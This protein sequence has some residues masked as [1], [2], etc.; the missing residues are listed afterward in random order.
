METKDVMELR[1][2]Q[3][4]EHLKSFY[5]LLEKKEANKRL[6]HD[7]CEQFNEYCDTLILNPSHPLSTF[8]KSHHIGSG[9]GYVKVVKDFLFNT[10]TRTPADKICKILA[11]LVFDEEQTEEIKLNALKALLGSNWSPKPEDNRYLFKFLTYMLKKELGEEYDIIL[12]RSLKSIIECPDTEI[13]TPASELL[14]AYANKLYFTSPAESE[15]TSG[16]QQGL[17]LRPV[18][19]SPELRL[20]IIQTLSVVTPPTGALFDFFSKLIQFSDTILIDYNNGVKQSTATSSDRRHILKEAEAITTLVAVFGACATR[21]PGCISKLHVE[22]ISTCSSLLKM[23]IAN[24]LN[25]GSL[26][27]LFEPTEVARLKK[28]IIDKKQQ[29]AFYAKLNLAVSDFNE[30][31]LESVIPLLEEIN[32]TNE[33]FIDGFIKHLYQNFRFNLLSGVKRILALGKEFLS[34]ASAKNL[35]ALCNQR[36]AAYDTSTALEATE[37]LLLLEPNNEGSIKRLSEALFD[38]PYCV[39]VSQLLSQIPVNPQILRCL[40]TSALKFKE[41]IIFR[42]G[43]PQDIQ[44]LLINLCKHT[45]YRNVVLKIFNDISNEIEVLSQQSTLTSEEGIRL[46]QLKSHVLP[47]IHLALF[48]AGIK[49]LR[50]EE[51]L[52]FYLE[53]YKIY[54]IG[55]FLKL[56]VKDH[57]RV[58]ATLTKEVFFGD[59]SVALEA[60]AILSEG[61]YNNGLSLAFALINNYFDPGRVLD[62][63]TKYNFPNGVVKLIKNDEERLVLGDIL[64]RYVEGDV[65][66][67]HKKG[68]KECLLLL[69]N[70]IFP[71]AIAVVDIEKQRKVF[72]TNMLI[73]A[74]RNLVSTAEPFLPK[75]VSVLL[76][77]FL[78]KAE[79][80]WEEVPSKTFTLK[81]NAIVRR[82]R[83]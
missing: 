18:I 52:P 30:D 46:Y 69:A 73:R 61:N 45:A 17:I 13:A 54:P 63:S 66:D 53:N 41:L 33:E 27:V 48:T 81:S 34:E 22:R 79:M 75:P 39:Q 77:M 2:E 64:K 76:H 12:I 23:E 31:R 62:E 60:A 7:E 56:L 44:A 59:L 32:A 6:T 72:K 9:D 19:G 51:H 40:E 49:N 67:D 20:E 80:E 26:S 58:V 21:Q 83:L 70:Q 16:D 43:A 47:I 74:D 10:E 42:S 11:D 82:D 57:P 68:L 15:A 1:Q 28:E 8:V 38:F 55:S 14:L 35:V 3:A 37:A 4:N 50:V 5:K 78:A 36:V 29:D 65:N 24:H 25:E 71:N